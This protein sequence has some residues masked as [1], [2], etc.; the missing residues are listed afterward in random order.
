MKQKGTAKR[1]GS[2]QSFDGTKIYYETHG[3]GEPIIMIYGLACLI[4]HWHFQI[5]HF[6]QN[7]QVIAFDIRGHHKS[8]IPTNPSNLTLDAISKDVSALL[9]ELGIRK[10]HFFGHSLGVQALL[11][12]YEQFPEHFLSMVLV[13]GFARNPI[14]GM[15]GTNIME[16][17]F[18]FF[19]SRF[20]SHPELMSTIWLNMIDNPVA[21]FGAGAV[22][23]FNM[24][25]APVRDMEIYARGV[26]R[27]PMSVFISFFEDMMAFRGDQVAPTVSIPSL[28]IGG[29]RDGVTPPR[30]QKDLHEQ[31]PQSEY[32][33][34]PYG[35]HCTQL[36][37]PDYVNLKIENFLQRPHPPASAQTLQSE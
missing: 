31:I 11:K 21:I 15:F 14:Q 26:S 18:Y 35:S 33:Q 23:G 4:N 8:A 30:F 2:F 20:E 32:L 28:I 7:Y 3:Q 36:D 17:L 16:N 27:V 29:D 24:R 37:F 5:E 34:V 10:A 13:N 1:V 6:S 9:R 19:K 22:G 25:L 12:A